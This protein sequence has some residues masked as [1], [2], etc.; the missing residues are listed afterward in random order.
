MLLPVAFTECFRVSIIGMQCIYRYT[1]LHL[2]V[3]S[4]LTNELN[5]SKK[6][7]ESL[8]VFNNIVRVFI[9]IKS[10]ICLKLIM[11]REKGSR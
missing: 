6:A 4:K 9:L 8:S 1:F 11:R 7:S 3:Y 10:L 2:F 5:C